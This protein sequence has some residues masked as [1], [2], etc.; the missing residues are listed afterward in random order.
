MKVSYLYNSKKQHLNEANSDYY[1]ISTGNDKALLS[2]AAKFLFTFPEFPSEGYK[3]PIPVQDNAF[4]KYI[5]LSYS[6]LEMHLHNKSTHEK[7][8][9]TEESVKLIKDFLQAFNNANGT[10][11]QICPQTLENTYRQAGHCITGNDHLVIIDA[12]TNKFCFSIKFGQESKKDTSFKEGLKVLFINYMISKNTTT[13]NYSLTLDEVL[14]TEDKFKDFMSFITQIEDSILTNSKSKHISDICGMDKSDFVNL[15]DYIANS[16][17]NIIYQF[18]KQYQ[19]SCN[20]IYKLAANKNSFVTR[21]T[22]YLEQYRADANKEAKSISAFTKAHPTDIIMVG[23]V[24][25]YQTCDVSTID[26]KTILASTAVSLKEKVSRLGKVTYFILGLKAYYKNQKNDITT[27]KNLRDTYLYAS[28]KELMNSTNDM[29]S[30]KFGFYDKFEKLCND[31]TVFMPTYSGGSKPVKVTCKNIKGLET[32]NDSISSLNENALSNLFFT[33]VL[34]STMKSSTEMTNDSKAMFAMLV[35]DSLALNQSKYYIA[36][37]GAI[38]LTSMGGESNLKINPQDVT[39]I[40]A[41]Y[42]GNTN[43]QRK[44]THI[45]VSLKI[46]ES[47]FVHTSKGTDDNGDVQVEFDIRQNKPDSMNTM[48]E[49]K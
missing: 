33:A 24:I 9:K 40:E 18:V 2:N 45:M 6:R 46:K 17:F 34:T 26:S 4:S 7:I 43:A 29:S 41:T 30:S 35:N 19:S 14:N 25:N 42:T 28:I 48:I 21:E 5:D 31:Y 3:N 20:L 27:L 47:N 32:G 36:K 23:S 39:S 44:V 8:L 10:N 16:G 37:D 11:L 1:Y 12:S 15:K 49:M 13:I 22:L 38:D